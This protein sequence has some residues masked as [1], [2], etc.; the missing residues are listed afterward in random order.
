MRWADSRSA[1]LRRGM[2]SDDQVIGATWNSYF[3]L[4]PIAPLSL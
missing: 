2:V 1:H 3:I 4:K